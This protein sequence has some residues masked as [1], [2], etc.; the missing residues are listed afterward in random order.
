MMI[1]NDDW[2]EVG[3]ETRYFGI[4]DF[5]LHLFLHIYIIFIN[6]TSYYCLYFYKYLWTQI[7]YNVLYKIN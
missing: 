1:L 3:G 5:S 4:H 6:Y 7:P 2:T